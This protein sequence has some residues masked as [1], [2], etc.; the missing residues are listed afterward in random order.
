MSLAD[1]NGVATEQRDRK[2][3]AK[4][5]APPPATKPKPT[6]A[7]HEAPK[8][9]GY[10]EV[11]TKQA[12]PKEL[13]EIVTSD[14]SKDSF[15]GGGAS[16]GAAAP[17]R[18]QVT[19]APSPKTSAPPPPPPPMAQATV[20]QQPPADSAKDL[21]GWA[22]SMHDQAVAYAKRGD[23]VSAGRTAADV[24]NRAPD[25]YA[26]SMANDRALKPCMAYIDTAIDNDAEKSSKARA[27]KRVNADEAPAAN[28]K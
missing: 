9:K 15:G 13:D 2:V 17:G 19:N 12:E 11:Q 16:A 8:K 21:I 14:G 5:D 27:S 22:K 18:A 23:C 24:K 20:A 28:V 25:Y 4:A 10:V 7:Y 6:A 1:K 3:I 26:K